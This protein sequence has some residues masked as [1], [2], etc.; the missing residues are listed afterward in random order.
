MEALTWKS[1]PFALVETSTGGVVITG[2]RLGVPEHESPKTAAAYES[3]AIARG[4]PQ[5]I[6]AVSCRS[7]F[8]NNARQGL[9]FGCAPPRA[10]LSRGGH[11]LRCRRIELRGLC[12]PN[13]AGRL[14][15]RRWRPADVCLDDVGGETPLCVTRASL[16]RVAV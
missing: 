13:G 3:K 8:V 16:S 10:P 4:A 12:V 5:N 9:P 15:R 6:A 7:Q 2:S 14:R 1:F 11:V